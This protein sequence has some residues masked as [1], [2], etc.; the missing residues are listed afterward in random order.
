MTDETLI[1]ITYT[2][3]IFKEWSAAVNEYPKITVSKAKRLEIA[4][5]FIEILA[6]EEL[7]KIKINQEII[8]WSS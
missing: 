5:V 7:G 1:T 8:N 4:K 3:N 6:E 2:E